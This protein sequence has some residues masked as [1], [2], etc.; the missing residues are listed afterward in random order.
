MP[1]DA[2]LA[3]EPTDVRTR[4][5]TAARTTRTVAVPRNGRPSGLLIRAARAARLFALPGTVATVADRAMSYAVSVPAG[6][7]ARPEPGAAKGSADVH[8]PLPG[9]DS[10]NMPQTAW[11]T[12]SAD[13]MAAGGKSAIGHTN[14]GGPCRRTDSSSG[15]ASVTMPR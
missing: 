10:I 14:R 5:T 2:L 6:P 3:R 4:S 9:M 1:G 12:A 13:R 15:E 8:G 7:E 11:S